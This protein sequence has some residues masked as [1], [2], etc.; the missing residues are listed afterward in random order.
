MSPSILITSKP[1]T[2][3]NELNEV[4]KARYLLQRLVWRD[5]KV[6]YNNTA[7]GI[8]W[9]VLQPLAMMVIFVLFLGLLFK[10]QTFG[11][12]TS[13]YTY[14]ALCLWHFFSRALTQGGMAFISYNDIIKKVYFPRLIAPLSYV[15][16]AAVDFA[17][18]YGLLLILQ[19]FYGVFNFSQFIFVPLIFSGLF[20][21]AFSISVLFAALSARYKDCVLIIPLLIQLWVFCCPIMYPYSIVP[22]RYLMLYNLNPLVGYIQMFRWAVTTSSPFPELSCCLV[23]I[24]A[25]IGL[26]VLSLLYFVRF[27]STLVDE[28]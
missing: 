26:T 24:I 14:S 9:N 5:L 28:I 18:A 2:L 21:F 19:I 15:L 23:S 25:T 13:I 16:G 27:S 12:P 3:L 1:P 17:V 22:E 6:R 8:L 20:L 10:N 11:I 4:F 7:L